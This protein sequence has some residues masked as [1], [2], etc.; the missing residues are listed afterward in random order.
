MAEI[1]GFA[2]GLPT[3]LRGD[4]GRPT[5]IT[6]LGFT[7][8]DPGVARLT[9]REL[10]GQIG[11]LVPLG[12]IGALAA[13]LATRIRPSPRLGALLVLGCWFAAGAIV[14][15]FT[16]GVVHP[17]YMAGI[18]P[19]LAGLVGVG[20]ATFR[21]DLA[22]GRM[23]AVLGLAGVVVSAFTEWAI[24]R[25]FQWRG[26]F[27]AVFVAAIAV[28]AFVA[29]SLIARARRPGWLTESRAAVVV[30][31][32]IVAVLL[33]PAMWTQ[34][35]LQAGVSGPL[36]YAQPLS[37][38]AGV[39]TANQI[40]PN[41]GFQYP[42]ISVPSLI[43]YLRAHRNG[44]RWAVA[45][46]S[47]APAEE[48]I[49][50]GGDPV[51]AVGGFIGT[52]PIISSTGLRAKVRDGE[53]RYFLLPPGGGLMPGLLRGVGSLSWVTRDC[54][55]VPVADWEHGAGEDTAKPGTP[56]FP[57]GPTATA[58]QLYDCRGAV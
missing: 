39:T 4:A 56:A 32:A 42:S 11:W 7:S 36:P 38:G 5:P 58:F 26:W 55:V 31:A 2:E 27:A 15:S 18:G 20:A 23:R 45:V 10:G 19:P 1:S 29:A 28:V 52:D 22:A 41:G 25:R 40:T 8:G 33:A 49:I 16:K 37:I 3:V 48:I 17:Y 12:V 47:A 53:V 24:W 54:T 13:L 34:G 44:E 51:M 21:F 57:G 9:D 46:E 6:A 43:E 35:S 30:A 14:F 50:A